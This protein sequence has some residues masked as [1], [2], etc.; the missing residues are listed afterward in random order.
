MLQVCFLKPPLPGTAEPKRPDPLR[1]GAFDARTALIDVFERV[2]VLVLPHGL[3]GE[4]LRFRVCVFWLK[5]ALG[6]F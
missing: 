1:E 3:R 6:R 4:L 2:G 5:A